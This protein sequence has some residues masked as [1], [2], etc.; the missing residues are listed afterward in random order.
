MEGSKTMGKERYRV[1]AIRHVTVTRIAALAVAAGLATLGAPLAAAAPAQAGVT[2]TS[3]FV[4]TAS[5]SNTSGDTSFI[6]NGATNSQPGD[7][8]FVTP[9]W[10]ATGLCGCVYEQ[11]PIGVWYDT[12]NHEWGVFREDGGTMPANEAYNVLAVPASQV[13]SSVFVQTSTSANTA[14]DYTLINSSATNG[15][16]N[17]QLQVTQD[18]NPGGSGGKYNPHNIGVWYD[19]S[20]GKWGIFNEDLAAM[21]TGVSFNVMVGASPSNGGASSVAVASSSNTSGDTIYINNSQTTGN[22][23]NVTFVT[24]NWNPGGSGGTYNNVQTGV[25]FN[26]S[27]EGAF[28]ENGSSPPVNS[29][30]NLLI[31]PS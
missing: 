22:P 24:Q 21:P 7:L 29:A 5:S 23:N 8:L 16:P 3:H 26:G 19:T 12:S 27:E 1:R 2:V 25:W 28:D 31:F 4:W 10:D 14:G 11:Y 6:S 15:N 18:W 17:A 30:Y 13:G 9:N 20:A